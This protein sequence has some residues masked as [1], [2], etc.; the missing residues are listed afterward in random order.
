MIFIWIFFFFV[1]C[2]SYLRFN[3]V[4][5]TRRLRILSF[6]GGDELAVLSVIVLG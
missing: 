3:A 1:L 5:M 2:G 6:F 4:F